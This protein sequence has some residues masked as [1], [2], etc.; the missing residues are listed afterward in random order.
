MSQ[1][2]VEAVRAAYAA[3]GEGDM[4]P[5][6]TL[7]DEQGAFTEPSSLPYGGTYRGHAGLDELFGKLDEHWEGLAF[8]VQKV[9]DA[10]DH[11]I[12]ISRVS[13]R[14]R[15]TGRT[16]AEPITEVLEMR[17]GKIADSHSRLDTARLLE[18][19]GVGP[20]PAGA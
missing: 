18:A 3:I 6:L 5:Y 11:V 1:Q 7:F 16:F 4:D 2:D 12:V 10:G 15:A 19:L 14:A 9:L 20:R 8:D 13:G 17:G